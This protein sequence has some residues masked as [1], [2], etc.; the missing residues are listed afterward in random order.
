MSEKESIIA[1][2]GGLAGWNIVVFTMT[3]VAL[4]FY[5]MTSVKSLLMRRSHAAIV[6]VIFLICAAVISIYSLINFYMRTTDL[7]KTKT[8]A[9]EKRKV[10]QSRI[11]YTVITSLIV[12]AQI[13]ITISIVTKKG[14][15]LDMFHAVREV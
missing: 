12:L 11:I 1:Q 10:K 8:T 5:H 2:E 14:V 6:T 13:I 3:T 4:L 9:E 7:E 15:W